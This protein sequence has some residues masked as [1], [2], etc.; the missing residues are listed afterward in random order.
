MLIKSALIQAFRG[1]LLKRAQE[2]FL[3]SVFT[4]ALIAMPGDSWIRFSPT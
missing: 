4:S 2:V 3:L 1:V